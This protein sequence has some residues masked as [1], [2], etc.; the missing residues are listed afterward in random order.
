MTKH[1][2]LIVVGGICALLVSMGIS[3]FAY[4]PILPLMQ[5]DVGFTEA[6][7]GIFGLQQFFRV[8][9]WCLGGRSW[10]VA[11]KTQRCNQMESGHQR[12][13]GSRNGHDFRICCV[14]S[15][16]IHFRNDER[17]FI[18][19]SLQ[20]RFGFS[21]RTGPSSMVGLFFSGVGR[22]I[23]LCGCIVPVLHVHLGWQG[24]WL[25]LACI[26][27]ALSLFVWLS[28]QDDKHTVKND[29]QEQSTRSRPANGSGILPWLL[30]LL[31]NCSRTTAATSSE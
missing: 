4:T 17:F 29:K 31:E 6:A 9:A 1:P 2:V 15:D 11:G 23:L 3:R 18:R 16:A 22:G 26:P 19:P 21:S 7:E 20:P 30:L 14:D 12:A 5:N 10:Q 24:I 25:V 28:L 8:S 13:L 27:L